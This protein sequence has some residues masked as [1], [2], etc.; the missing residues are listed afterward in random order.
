MVDG[1]DPS[2]V[3]RPEH[4]IEAHA[5]PSPLAA[6]REI[7]L[8]AGTM[9]AFAQRDVRVRYKQAILGI[10]W[11]ALQPLALM[12]I[13][14][15]ALSRFGIRLDTPVTYRAFALATVVPWIYLQ[16]AVSSGAQAPLTEAA[17]IRKVYFPREMPIF[18]AVLGN[19]AGLIVGLT[20][21]VIAAIPIGARPGLGWF[22]LPVLILLTALL[23]AAVSLLCA[24][25]NVYYR[26]VRY[27]LPFALQLWMFASPVIYPLSHVPPRWRALFTILNPAAGLLDSWYRVLAAG[28][29]PH[30]ARLLPSVGGI[31]ILLMASYVVFK[32]FE[33]N[34]AD[35]L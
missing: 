31:A 30:S 12:A 5:S 34:L 25:P 26:D 16:S 28:A 15:F 14:S 6:I 8:F 10:L 17:V 3:A 21:Y 20:V 27:V 7:R 33:P 2:R 35:V 23:A 22:F 29:W 18:G 13:F 1:L 9:L 19:L 4:V 11:S 24:G 32:R